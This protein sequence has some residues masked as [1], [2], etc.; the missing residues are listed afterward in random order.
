M[1]DSTTD[2]NKHITRVQ[3]LLLQVSLNLQARAVKHDKSKLQPPEK[4]IFDKYTTLL[5]ETTYGSTQYDQYLKEMQT[6]LDHHYANNTHHPQYYINGIDGM[7]LLDIIEMFCDWKAATE[8]HADGNLDK[9]IIHNEKRF[10]INPQITHIF[11]NTK[12]ELGW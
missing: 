2:T 3:E 10:N 4:E 12:K 11:E 6:G 9:S 7:T 1:Y 5:K 8:R